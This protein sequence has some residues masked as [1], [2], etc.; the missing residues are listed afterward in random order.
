MISRVRQP[1]AQHPQQRR[2][3]R[4]AAGDDHLVDVPADEVAIR[5]RDALRGER[6]RGGDQIVGR[7]VR[8]L[9]GHARARTAARNAR[10]PSSS[11]A[12]SWKYGSDMHHASTSSRTRAARGAR[13]VAVERLRAVRDEIHQRVDDHVAGPGVERDDVVE[14]SRSAG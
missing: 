6:R 5:V 11:A 4:A 14:R 12:C 3:F 1:L 8:K 10:V 9:L 2:I 13:A 7:D